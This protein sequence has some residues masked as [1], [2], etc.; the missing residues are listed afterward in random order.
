FRRLKKEIAI[1][2]KLR[3]PHVVRLREVIDAKENPKVFLVLEYMEGG[4]VKWKSDDQPPTP[5]LTTEQTRRM[6]RDVVLG[7]E[8][9][10]HQG[11]IHRDIKPANL[12]WNKDH[13][14]V[15][16][17]DFGVSH[18]SSVLRLASGLDDELDG[19]NSDAYIALD[20]EALAKTAGSPA[21]F[22]PEL[23]YNGDFTPL[24]PS[25]PAAS[26]H[27][28][29]GDNG[30]SFFPPTTERPKV[31]KAIDVWALGVTL[32]CLLFAKV[33]F[34]APTEFALFAVIPN[35]DFDV[36]RWAGKERFETGGKVPGEGAS[37]EARELA[38]LLKGMLEKNP[39]KRIKL[40]QVKVSL[41][42]P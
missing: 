36:P 31:T 18:Y 10:H 33:P 13:S 37:W 17:S 24:A 11:I 2:K 6:F 32:Y 5:L 12:L 7:L 27:H 8:Y 41:R 19:I 25:S 34:E 9:L 23:C 20:E 15:K 26:T 16:I 42:V 29:N 30:N 38:D 21:F 14:V 35:E 4:E 39:E 22:A 1:L 3:H 40:E 28:L